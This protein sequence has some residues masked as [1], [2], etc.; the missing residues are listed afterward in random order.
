MDISIKITVAV[1]EGSN[2][3]EHVI[4]LPYELLFTI[5]AHPE[6]LDHTLDQTTE[7][8]V[9]GMRGFGFDNPIWKSEAIR[10]DRFI[11]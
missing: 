6:V 5:N 2:V 7:H 4:E 8:I 10:H 9:T 11:H 3:C 1:R